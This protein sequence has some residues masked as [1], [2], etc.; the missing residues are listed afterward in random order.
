MDLMLEH[1]SPWRH[2]PR[3]H[4]ALSGGLDSSVL[5]HQL[6][7]LARTTALP[8][9]HAIHVH[10]GLQAAADAWPQHCQR[11]C[12]ALGV[13]LTVTRVQVAPGASLEA[14]ARTARYQA[15]E[16][17]LGAGEVLLTGQHQD[18]QAETL[19]FR[20]LRGAG[21]RGLAAMATE[22]PLGLGWL[23]RPLLRVSRAELHAYAQ[24]HQLDW[25]DDP[26]N[27]DTRFARNYLRHA[28]LPVLAQR[29]PQAAQTFARAA[30]HLAEA[31]GLLTEVAEQDVQAARTATPLAWLTVPSLD[32]AALRALSDARQRNALQHWLSTLT[33]LPDAQHW[34]GWQDLRDAAPSATPIWALADGQLQRAGG[35]LWWLADDWSQTPTA[36]VDWALP[37]APLTL[38]GNGEVRLCGP[39]PQGRVQIRYRQGGEVLHIAGRGHRDLKRLL[40]ESG[41]PPFVRARLPLLFVDGQLQAVANLPLRTGAAADLHW[42]PPTNAQRLR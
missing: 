2:A 4:I 22:R 27:T 36:A 37:A 33:R 10:H 8:P 35:R 42:L 21:V 15:F 13:P 20:L 32:M 14:A 29:W 16:Q 1:L 28:V 31:Q 25:V 18:D 23:V 30:E 5:L 3:W 34:A 9:L 6:A 40:N 17:A 26:S 11:L 38:P 24:A 19:L 7:T 12:D 41:L 39:V